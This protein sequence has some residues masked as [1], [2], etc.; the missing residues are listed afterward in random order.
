MR[1]L[2]LSPSAL[3]VPV[4]VMLLSCQGEEGPPNL[5]TVSWAGVVCGVPPTVGV[6]IRAERYSHALIET[7]GE[8]VLNIPPA[9]LL[10]VADFC[11]T[12]SGRTV[13]KFQAA[14]LTPVP[15]DKVR[16]PLVQECPINLECVVRQTLP[17]G[18]H[19]L[20]LAEVVAL[21]ADD[22]VVEEGIVVVG[23]VAP[24]AFDPFGGDYWGLRD[25]LGHYGYSDGTMPAPP[26]G[27]A[28]PRLTR[29]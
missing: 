27:P 29:T 25:V 4:P 22:T 7:S 20:F 11:G 16:T 10:R 2:A 26:A 24:L 28:G 14:G 13:D 12:V 3:L 21:H 6:A 17:L 18:S 5:T 15:G 19:T 8:F 9:S 1:K 23:R